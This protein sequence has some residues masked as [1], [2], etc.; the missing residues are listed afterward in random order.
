M[1]RAVLEI[2]MKV[3]VNEKT[4]KKVED[5]LRKCTSEYGT[6]VSEVSKDLNITRV[7]ARKYLEVLVAMGK[8]KKRQIGDT[9]FYS[10]IK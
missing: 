9:I 3:Y 6:I 5:Y 8:A 4:L 2:K 1:K 7:T 10:I